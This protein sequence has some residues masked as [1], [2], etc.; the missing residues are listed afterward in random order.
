[1]ALPVIYLISQAGTVT[2]GIATQAFEFIFSNLNTATYAGLLSNSFHFSKAL[3]SNVLDDFPSQLNIKTY[4]DYM[5]YQVASA[6]GAYIG[7]RLAGEVIT[8]RKSGSSIFWSGG[9]G[10]CFVSAYRWTNHF[11][12]SFGGI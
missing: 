12:R 11:C 9:V 1:M 3:P 8:P 6:F 10:Y 5:Q 7:G 4:G 2:T